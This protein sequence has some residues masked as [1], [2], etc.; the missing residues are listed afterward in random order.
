MARIPPWV[1][2]VASWV[3]ELEGR[4]RSPQ[5][6]QALAVFIGLHVSLFV[7]VFVQGT[8]GFTGYWQPWGLLTLIVAACQIHHSRAAMRGRR[9]RAW[10]LT[11]GL[12]TATV[13]ALQVIIGPDTSGAN[14]ILL[15]ASAAMVLPGRYPI[16]WTIPPTVAATGI[17][18]IVPLLKGDPTVNEWWW[19]ALLYYP[20]I[21]FLGAGGL[22][23]SGHL[24]HQVRQLQRSRVELAESAVQ[25]ERMRVARDLHDLLGQSLSAV[26]LKSELAL[27]LQ[28]SDPQRARREVE[29]LGSIA[30]ATLADLRAVTRDHRD[31]GLEGEMAGA[32]RL[33]DAAGVRAEVHFDVG[34]LAPAVDRLLGWTLREG[35]TNVLRHSDATWCTVRAAR[36]ELAV[37]LEIVNDRPAVAGERGSGLA[38]LEARARELGGKLTT[39]HGGSQFALSLDVPV[40]TS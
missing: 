7:F 3:D 11:L 32:A 29:D 22:A 23:V 34:T 40:A 9:A 33:L 24:V 38:G 1:G 15:A 12:M 14:L 16:L 36:K 5:E 4:R 6:R 10:P 37:K 30:G 18:I 25:R 26:V 31:T 2:P 27:R 35:I 21:H 39:V 13:I 20:T 8:T 17:G 28:E 19:W